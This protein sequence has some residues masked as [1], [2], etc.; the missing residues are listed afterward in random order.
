MAGWLGR[1]QWLGRRLYFLLFLIGPLLV[2]AVFAW[3]WAAHAPSLRKALAIDPPAATV[4]ASPDGHTSVAGQ[5]HDPTAETV[6]KPTAPRAAASPPGVG[7]ALTNGRF[8]WM[9]FHFGVQVLYPVMALIAFYILCVNLGRWSIPALSV[10]GLM[11]WYTISIMMPGDGGVSSQ[12]A[13]LLLP[14]KTHALPHYDPDFQALAWEGMLLD[15]HF[16]IILIFLFPIAGA[17]TL[18]G[19]GP[20]EMVAPQALHR[21]RLHLKVII[22]AASFVLSFNTLYWAE[23]VAWPAHF[24]PATQGTA[25]AGTAE[26]FRSYATG[27]RLYFG[28]SYTLA[29]F[30]FAIPAVLALSWRRS[31]DIAGRPRRRGRSEEGQA[32]LG[33]VVFTRA[34]LATVLSAVGPI[35]SAVIADAVQL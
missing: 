30:A 19:T 25:T 7:G 13:P 22:V 28:A 32:Y 20:G 1:I 12:S 31:E 35:V 3:H 6:T 34:E 4:M 33:Q 17:A 11:T 14:T 21:K 23:W 26:E 27:L 15:Y 2:L 18:F 10:A 5:S 29:L 8:E 24:L 9:T 16:V